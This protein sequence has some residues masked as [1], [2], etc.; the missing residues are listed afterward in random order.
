MGLHEPVDAGA[1][2][3]DGGGHG[4][5]SP[6]SSDGEGHG[7]TTAPGWELPVHTGKVTEIGQHTVPRAQEI[8]ERIVSKLKGTHPPGLKIRRNAINQC[9]EFGCEV[10]GRLKTFSWG[11]PSK[12]SYQGDTED[13]AIAAG[14]AYICSFYEEGENVS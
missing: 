14:I 13:A 11:I 6:A 9:Y 12:L 7:E 10:S 1:N 5:G 4:G 3:D 8:R 2:P